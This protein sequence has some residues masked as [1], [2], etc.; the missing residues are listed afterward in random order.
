MRH[1]IWPGLLALSACV[2]EQ[3]AADMPG[4][5]DPKAAQ[6]LVGQQRIDDNQAKKLSGA[7]IVRQVRP[8]QPMTM[9]LRPDR[10][11]IETDPAT[12]KIVNAS[13]V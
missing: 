11:T 3:P 10:I 13:C 4:R 1:A 7:A 6:A 8:G 5:C 2:S 9:D 12:G